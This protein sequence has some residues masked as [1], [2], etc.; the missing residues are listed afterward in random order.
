LFTTAK[1]AIVSVINDL[2][3]DSRVNKTCK[4]L[5][6]CGYRVVLIGRKLPTSLPVP[7][8]SYKAIRMRLL[9]TSGPLF[10]FFFN[11]RLF[12]QL[13]FRKAHLLYANDLDT[14]L[15]NF[16]VSK[17]KKLPL[18]YD[19]HE[20]FCEVPEL[21]HTPLKKKIWER[22][23]KW[24]VP[25]LNTCITVNNSIALIYERKYGVQFHVVR[26]ISEKPSFSS[27]LSRSELGI[28]G[29]AKIIV[30]QGAGINV[31]R[32][33]EELVAAMVNVN[34]M[35]LIIGS[36][37]VW[38]VLSKIVKDLGLENKVR[39][40]PRIPKE[41]LR[42]YTRQ[43]DL[44][45]S[46]DKPTNMNYVNSLP[47]KIF[48]YIQA[49]IP[50]MASRLP[51]IEK[52]ITGYDIGDFI[53]NHEPAHIAMKLSEMLSSPRYDSWK[54]NTQKAAEQFNWSSEKEVLKKIIVRLS[55]EVK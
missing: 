44:G 36:G 32:G 11:L 18:I 55:E 9:F 23:E 49:G 21:Q 25:R 31:Q 41:D 30:L 2:V 15:P 27:L 45:I 53:E 38:N 4:V 20:L 14:L 43:A 10:Y 8:W 39:L 47:N 26:N 28:P 51:E 42:H 34:A 1:I 7:A 50:I 12:L 24:M 17:L 13:L 40:I 46:I 6:E 33:A 52:I 54:G 19:S 35:L 48:D 3:T 29:N 22:L 5:E 16:L 37:D